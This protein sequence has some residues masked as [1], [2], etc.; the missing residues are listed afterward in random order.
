MEVISQ[1]ALGVPRYNSSNLIADIRITREFILNI[2]FPEPGITAIVT[3]PGERKGRS[4]RAFE[5][6]GFIPLRT[7]ELEGKNVRRRI[8]HPSL[9]AYMSQPLNVVAEVGRYYR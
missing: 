8:M 7:T 9:L 3:Y 6:M 2:V 1:P 5:K 4:C